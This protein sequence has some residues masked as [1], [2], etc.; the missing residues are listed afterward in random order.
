VS[1]TKLVVGCMSV[2][3]GLGSGCAFQQEQVEQQ[4]Q[5]PGPVNCAT[6]D[7]DLRVLRSEKADVA[8]RIVEGATAVYPAG[9]V[10]GVVTGVE[11][12]KLKVAIGEYNMAIDNR[13][14]EI[15]QTCG[16]R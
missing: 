11:S 8:Q 3:L 2:L 4:L 13:I 9:A 5:H 6:A 12:T 1:K 7:G 14:A 15:Q 16:S 10:M